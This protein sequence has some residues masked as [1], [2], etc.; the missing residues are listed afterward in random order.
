MIAECIDE[1]GRITSAGL[2]WSD[3]AWT[4]SL[5][6]PADAFESLRNG[7]LREIE[8]RLAFARVTLV[9]GW[10]GQVGKLVVARVVP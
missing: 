10:A 7:E 6:Q 8:K 5:G 2:I 4:Q 1:T 3:I 9:F